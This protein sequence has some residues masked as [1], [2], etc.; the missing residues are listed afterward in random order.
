VEKTLISFKDSSI[1]SL[2]N[3][4]RKMKPS[5]FYLESDGGYGPFDGKRKTG[6]SLQKI[7]RKTTDVDRQRSSGLLVAE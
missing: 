1:G 6:L 5:G 4:Q 3:N 2:I 7:F